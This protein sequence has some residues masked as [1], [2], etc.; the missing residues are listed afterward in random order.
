MAAGVESAVRGRRRERAVAVLVA[1]VTVA[2][3]LGVGAGATVIGAAATSTQGAGVPVV[4]AG[5]QSMPEAA[6]A[7]VHGTGLPGAAP[8]Y[9][10]RDGALTLS[11]YEGVS[12]PARILARADVWAGAIAAGLAALLLVP[13]LRS[14][15]SRDPF[16]P[17]NARRLALAA[18][19]AGMGWLAS[20]TLPVA[21]AS[22]VVTSLPP[23]AGAWEPVFRPEYWPLG[24]VA[25]LAALAYAT[26][27]GSRLVA[28]TEGLV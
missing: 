10:Q 28:D 7:V 3:L 18:G 23:E 8:V 13:V 19:V 17:R 4:A 21:A 12:T 2:G 22:L 1:I 9:L 25:L 5:I 26:W 11:V 16:A 15:A 20:S 6:S 27:Q 24:F 14:T